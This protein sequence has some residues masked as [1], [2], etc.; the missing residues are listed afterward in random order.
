MVL[1]AVLFLFFRTHAH[2]CRQS[3]LTYMTV[4]KIHAGV[5][6]KEWAIR[7]EAYSEALYFKKK[8]PR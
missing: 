3:V 6:S 2:Y 5:N 1:A 4:M 8:L 7:G